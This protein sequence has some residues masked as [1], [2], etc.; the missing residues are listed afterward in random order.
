MNVYECVCVC[1]CMLNKGE[2]EV[3]KSI[4]AKFMSIDAYDTHTLT[5]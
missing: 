2:V 3:N 1:M 5:H 4:S